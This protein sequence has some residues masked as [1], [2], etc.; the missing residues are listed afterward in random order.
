MLLFPSNY[1][2]KI[3][4]FRNEIKLLIIIINFGNLKM[5]IGD[6]GLGVWGGGGGGGGG[7]ARSPAPP[8][9]TPPHHTTKKKKK[10]KK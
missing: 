6:W 8:P 10:K 7:G 3:M 5:G 9:P 4:I 1:S 2:L